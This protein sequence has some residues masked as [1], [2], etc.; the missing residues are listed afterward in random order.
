MGS[1]ETVTVSF[2]IMTEDSKPL[3][4]Y[5]YH[6]DRT[7]RRDLTPAEYLTTFHRED[8][9]EYSISRTTEVPYTHYTY[10]FP[11][12]GIGFQLSGN[13]ILRVAQQGME[14]DILFER[15][16]FVSESAMPLD[17]RLDNVLIAGRGYTSV[18]PF[19]QF[20][21][22]GSNVNAFD[23]SVC[24]VRND[25]VEAPRCS[26]R[27]GMSVQPDLA[28]YLE[29]EESFE[30][31]PANYFLDLKDI[32]I[33]GRI[34]YTDLSVQPP[35]VGLSPDYAS[36]PGTSQAPFLNGQ[37]V[38]ESV[39]KNVFDP[40]VSAEYGLVYF[41]YVPLDEVRASGRVVVSG[42]FNNWTYDLANELAWDAERR[43]Y[44]GAVLLKQGQYEYRYVV[45]D[46]RLQRAAQGA[47]PSTRSLYTTFVYLDDIRVQTDRLLVATGVLFY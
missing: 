33:G 34:E 39:V 14:E 38:V 3:T 47:P 36:F 25:V 41:R 10:Q 21:P 35:L 32:R 22:P 11:S 46:P 4:A 7:W 18:Q 45:D 17:V 30:Q 12:S 29:P 44:E 28:F 26:R 43:W 9:F 13:Y 8:L 15:P 42:S 5:F 16:F 23:Y 6:A 37:T 20:R 2:D 27:P 31:T 19:V 1:G 40:G 24:F